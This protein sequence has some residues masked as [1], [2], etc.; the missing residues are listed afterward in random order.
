MFFVILYNLYECPALH[1]IQVQV[2][3]N[4]SLIFFALSGA[5]GVLMSVRPFDDMLSGALHSIFLAQNSLSLLPQSRL[6]E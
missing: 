4:H 5:Q 1:E 2:N 3:V 6:R